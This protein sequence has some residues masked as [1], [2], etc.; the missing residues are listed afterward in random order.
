[1]VPEHV[2]SLLFLLERVARLEPHEL[3]QIEQNVKQHPGDVPFV[4]PGEVRQGD[5]LGVHGVDHVDHLAQHVLKVDRLLAQTRHA[6]Q[7]DFVEVPHLLGHQ[8]AVAIEIT[9]HEPVPQSRL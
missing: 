2:V 8:P 6:V 3:V 9:A 1:M 7:L 4:G 5:G